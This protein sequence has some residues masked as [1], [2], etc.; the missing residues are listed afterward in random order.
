MQCQQSNVKIG[1]IIEKKIRK[2][3]KRKIKARNI[4]YEV[5][6]P[7]FRS[8][9]VVYGPFNAVLATFFATRAVLPVNCVLKKILIFFIIFPILHLADRIENKLEVVPLNFLCTFRSKK[10]MITSALA[11]ISD[12]F[13]ST[14]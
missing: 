4:T 7:F 10:T 13:I 6:F 9:F 12:I 1:K 14:G 8:F 2:K 11:K 3:L 5:S